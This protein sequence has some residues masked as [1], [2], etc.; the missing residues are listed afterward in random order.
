MVISGFGGTDCPCILDKVEGVDWASCAPAVQGVYCPCPRVY[1]M[2]SDSPDHRKGIQTEGEI[3]CQCRGGSVNILLVIVMMKAWKA[4]GEK[5]LGKAR[6]EKGKGE[7][8]VTRL[9]E[10]RREV[11]EKLL[12]E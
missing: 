12:V 3:T 1:T 4:G 11:L 6:A 9:L 8:G 5:G 10:P 7:Q 2:G